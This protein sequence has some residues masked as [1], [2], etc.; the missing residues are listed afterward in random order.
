MKY[1]AIVKT[2][3]KWLKYKRVT[4]LIKFVQ[5]LDRS[6]PDWLFLNV[7][8]E[9]GRQIGAFTQEQRPLTPQI[10]SAEAIT[11]IHSWYY[12]R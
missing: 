8:D 5:F 10:S 7:Y 6:F 4:D 2:P 11:F 1:A 12:R 3:A 9:Q